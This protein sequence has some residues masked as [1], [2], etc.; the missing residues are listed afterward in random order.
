MLWLKHLIYYINTLN[1][2]IGKL[3][4]W[5]VLAMVIIIVYDVNARYWF[6]YGSVALQEWQW[7]LFALIFLLGSA[8][9]LK[10]DEHVRVDII[11]QSHW[12]NERRRAW[13]NLLGGLLFL[14]PFCLVILYS[15]W[16][17]VYDAYWHHESSPESGGLAYR[18]LL[19][20]AILVAFSL[21][22]LQ[23]LANVLSQVLYLF[24]HS[25][26]TKG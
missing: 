12:M 8:Y 23:G 3:A 7:H 18:F 16:P 5:L 26:E 21:L 1:D 17:F 13:V 25:N 11:Y 2:H 10:A 4:A 15:T 9:T 20:G 6:H 19:K 24:G 14:V 22:L